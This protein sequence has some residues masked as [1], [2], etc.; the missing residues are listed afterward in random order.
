MSF[1]I[2]KEEKKKKVYP[3]LISDSFTN[4]PG[5]LTGY[6]DY[7]CKRQI[8]HKSMQ[9]CRNSGKFQMPRRV[10][11]SIMTSYAKYFCLHVG[12]VGITDVKYLNKMELLTLLRYKTR[13]LPQICFHK[14]HSQ[15]H[16]IYGNQ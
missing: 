4:S 8:H 10:I 15:T 3:P 12:Q 16:F 13:T 5:L 2:K 6:F 1:F 14:I 7:V 11:S 9:V